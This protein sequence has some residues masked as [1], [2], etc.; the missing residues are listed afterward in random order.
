MVQMFWPKNPVACFFKYHV[1]VATSIS[2]DI[3][4]LISHQRYLEFMKPV[5]QDQNYNG[6]TQ[7]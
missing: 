3:F 7:L 5:E 1:W 4:Q 6:E 2:D